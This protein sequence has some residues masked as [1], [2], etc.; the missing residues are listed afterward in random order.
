MYKKTVPNDILIPQ[1]G[2]LLSEGHEV[3]LKPKG[4]S[5]LP[6]IR[7]DKDNVVLKKMESVSKGDIV[8]ADV[9]G[10]F[11]LHRIIKEEGDNLE[12]MGDGNIRGTEHCTRKD[13]LGTVIA[14]LKGNGR[15]VRPGKGKIWRA[16]LP[17]R[18]YLLA[19]YRRVLM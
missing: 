8:L 17:V 16:L 4:N 3:E 10:R 11:V 1:I 15:S 2:V 6:F 14:V 7:Q 5:M 12:L 18:R 9:G 13:V 19:F